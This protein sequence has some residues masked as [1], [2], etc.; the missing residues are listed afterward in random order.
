[1]SYW[2]SAIV[3]FWVV[4]GTT[5]FSS[6]VAWISLIAILVAIPLHWLFGLYASIV[7]YT[8][9][10]LLVVG[11]RATFLVTAALMTI[12]ALAGFSSAPIRVGIVF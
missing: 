10:T 2:A 4:F 5:E 6:E 8:G 9:L 1:M 11:L 3:S 7:R 12:S